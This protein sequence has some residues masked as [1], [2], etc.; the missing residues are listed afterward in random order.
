MLMPVVMMLVRLV[1]GCSL[2]HGVTPM[3][4]GQ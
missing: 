2:V 4:Q 1:M 3:V